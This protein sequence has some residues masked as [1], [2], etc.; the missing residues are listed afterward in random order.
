MCTGV[1]E[2]TFI[3]G[4]EVHSC[5]CVDYNSLSADHCHVLVYNMY[6]V[7]VYMEIHVRS[8]L[9]LKER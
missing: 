8:T 3:C 7:L 2:C 1:Y 5:C 9:A 4:D 6:I